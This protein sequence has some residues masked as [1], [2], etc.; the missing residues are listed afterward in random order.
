MPR[1][2]ISLPSMTLSSKEPHST[3]LNVSLET[4]VMLGIFTVPVKVK[5][6]DYFSRFLTTYLNDLTL[7]L[8]D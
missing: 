6:L 3:E 4:R 7:H 2:L 8:V 1:Q 5:K